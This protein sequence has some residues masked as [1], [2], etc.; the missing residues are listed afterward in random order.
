[1]RRAFGLHVLLLITCCSAQL[2]CDRAGT[3]KSRPDAQQQESAL[4]RTDITLLE[5]YINLPIKP[6]WAKWST[7]K[8][9]GGNDWDI[10]VLLYLKDEDTRRLLTNTEASRGGS[11]TVPRADL[12][13][14]FPTE[15]QAEYASK[16]DSTAADIQVDAVQ[17]PGSVFAAPEKSPAIHGRALVFEKHNL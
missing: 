2:A 16:L 14:W 3:A 12:V 8:Q 4:T 10:T 13:N 6:I 1:M 15:V 5:R 11:M 9:P 17:L 7:S